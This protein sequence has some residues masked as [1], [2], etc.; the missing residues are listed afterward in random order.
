MLELHDWKHERILILGMTYPHYSKKYQENVCTGA[1]LESTKEMIRIHPIPRRYMDVKF[2]SFQ[3]ITAK[4]S[5]HPHD[6]RPE[7]CRIDPDSIELQEDVPSTKS[8][9]RRAL[10]ESSPHRVASYEA[11]KVRNET[12]GTSLGIVCPKEITG[13]RLERRPAAER[14]EWAAAEEELLRQYDLYER[15]PRKIDFPEVRFM[16]SWIC[17]DAQ[18]KGHEMGIEQWGLHELYRKL[19]G[20]VGCDAK[21]LAEMRRRLDSKTRDIFLF[22][23]SFRTIM[24]NFGLMDSYSAP[25]LPSTGQLSLLGPA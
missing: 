4:I 22:L 23:G 8:E 2:K 17:D 20:D 15:P 6:P 13:C 16:V 7:S 9:V 18:C 5:K 19:R 10:L 3:W 24:Y 11:L 21:V 25:K 12:Q 14:L 1:L